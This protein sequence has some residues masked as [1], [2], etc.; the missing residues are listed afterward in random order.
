MA[1]VAAADLA[2]LRILTL[3][4][5]VSLLLPLEVSSL[6]LAL[7]ELAA[8]EVVEAVEAAAGLFLMSLKTRHIE[9][10]QTMANG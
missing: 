4:S 2:L 3:G 6:G 1:A 10:I 5:F 7:L 8:S 9:K